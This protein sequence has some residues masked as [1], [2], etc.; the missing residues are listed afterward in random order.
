[1]P[2]CYNCSLIFS[3]DNRKVIEMSK[4]AR[5]V[6]ANQEQV[7]TAL[8]AYGA[9][10][11]V[12]TQGDGL[13]DLLVGYTNPDSLTKYTLLLEVKDGNKPPS[14]RKLTP[15]EE[16]FFFEWTGGLLAVVESAEE[17]IDIL[18]NCR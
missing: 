16:K 15:A 11:R 18:K 1:M 2:L 3:I 17:A 14:A 10:V 7:V 5:R 4:Y 13:P 12:V 9:T 6:D 8:R